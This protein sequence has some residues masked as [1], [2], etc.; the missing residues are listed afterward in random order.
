MWHQNVAWSA[1]YQHDAIHSSIYGV[2]KC[3]SVCLS[4]AILY[5]AGTAKFV[6]RILSY[7]IIPSF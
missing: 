1:F 4:A 2:T 3:P 7:Q 5:C 6:A